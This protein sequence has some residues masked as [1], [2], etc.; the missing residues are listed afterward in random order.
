MRETQPGLKQYRV[1][2]SGEEGRGLLQDVNYYVA[3]GDARSAEY[4]ITVIQPPSA[5]VEQIRYEFPGYMELEPKTVPGGHIDTWEGTRITIEARANMPLRLA[6][7]V[8]S[9]TE[10][11]SEKAEELRM[12]IIDGTRLQVQW[13]AKF[14]SDGTHP[15]YYHIECEND[16]GD[17]D[18]EPTFYTISIQP[19]KPPEVRLLDPKG[20]L[21]RPANAVVPLRIEAR[22]PDFL[23]RYLTLRLEKNGEPL[24]V[25]RQLFDGR[26]QAVRM[27][28][29]FELE[30]LQLKPGD[31]L[32]YWVEARDNKRP[33]ANRKN[34]PKLNIKIIEPVSQEQVQKQL[35]QDRQRQAEMPTDQQS[36]DASQA[37]G[38]QAGQGQTSGTETNGEEQ[39]E[40]E[41]AE[42]QQP[43]SSSKQSQPGKEGQGAEPQAGRD[44]SAPGQPPKGER[45]AERPLRNDGSDD[46]EVL[47]RL[48]ARQQEA[49]ERQQPESGTEPAG[50]EGRSDRKPRPTEKKPGPKSEPD[51]SQQSSE[52]AGEQKGAEQSASEEG[53][54]EGMQQPGPGGEGEASGDRQQGQGTPSASPSDRREGER[55]PGPTTDAAPPSD[56]DAQTPPQPK[57]SPTTG[58]KGE[59]SPAEESPEATREKATG[60]ET[61]TGTPDTD[62]D[63]QPTP[64]QNDI[65]RK[66]GTE[67]AMRPGQPGDEI[68]P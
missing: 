66:P 59:E 30:P 41:G 31:L 1:L 53:Q 48:L 29:D 51:A 68:P 34:T 61:G 22:D 11:R 63:A 23:L 50:E 10:D 37:G 12:E 35:D 67:P 24:S 3:A 20:D 57:S 54:G 39:S 9:D 19:D 60:Q 28:Y 36:G 5:T 14:R 6:R 27:T 47:R 55:Q 56:S 58:P 44:A 25:V 17:V 45:S 4:R 65:Q 13:T 32:T 33:L 21:E 16:R 26:Q 7:L 8:F 64:A 46:D 49:Q 43:P 42:G 15:R 62:P 38:E 52:Q 40:S 18:P 2:L